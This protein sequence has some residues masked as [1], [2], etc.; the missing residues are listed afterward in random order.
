MGENLQVN[1]SKL[2]S[3]VFDGNL[4]QLQEFWNIYNAAIHKQQNQQIMPALLK[5]NH[6]KSVVKGLALSAI[7]G[8][9]LT[10]ENYLL[11]VKERFG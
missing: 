10:S 1:L 4:Q 7:A 8:I 6:L 3:P 5:F 9:L 11:V 2:Q